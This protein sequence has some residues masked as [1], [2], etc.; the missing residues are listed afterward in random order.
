MDSLSGC[1]TGKAVVRSFQLE[2]NTVRA[3]QGLEPKSWLQPRSC[4]FAIPPPPRNNWLISSM[5][6]CY[7]LPD[8]FI[9]MVFFTAITMSSFSSSRLVAAALVNS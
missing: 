6:S 1:P 9:D 7:L 8:S 4:V 2:H 3:K 5:C